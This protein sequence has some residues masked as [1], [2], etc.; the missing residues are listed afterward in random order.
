MTGQTDGFADAITADD[1]QEIAKL[2]ALLKEAEDRR[3]RKRSDAD[4]SRRRMDNARAAITEACAAYQR[5]WNSLVKE[6]RI[7]ARTLK[8]WGILPLES[9]CAEE[10]RKAQ[11]MLRAGTD[12][13]DQTTDLPEP[14]DGPDTT[15]TPEPHGDSGEGTPSQDGAAPW[16]GATGTSA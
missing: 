15:W 13:D 11:A 9:V 4:R 7:N 8:Q 14:A 3:K 2:K 10:R 6:H 5:E 12:G 1:E 16:D